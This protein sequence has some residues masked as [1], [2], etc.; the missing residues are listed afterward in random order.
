[1]IAT[2]AQRYYGWKAGL[3]GYGVA[4]AISVAR[5]RGNKHWASD[6]AAG[7]TLGYLVGSSVSRRTR[8]SIRGTEFSITPT[9]DLANRR[10]G[11]VLNVN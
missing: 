6:V 10:V 5:V 7:A 9:V 4:S 1:M 3:I 11:V 2:V 8:I